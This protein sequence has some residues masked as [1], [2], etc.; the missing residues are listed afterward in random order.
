MARTGI[1]T[2]DFFPFIGG[3]GRLTYTMYCGLKRKNILFFSPAAN[4]L[5]GHVRID[6]WA[7]RFFQQVGVTIWLHFNVHRI[8]ADYDLGKLNVHSGAGGVLLFRRV[9][10]PVVVT[11][12]HTYWQHYRYIKSQFWKRIFYPFERLTYKRADL[13]VADCEDTKRVLVDRYD[14]PERKITII[15]IAVNT[16]DFFATKQ[17]KEPGTILYIGRID[18]RKGV[19]FLIRSMPLVVQQVLDARLLIGGSGKDLDKMK[20]LVSR[21]DLERNVTF[22][23]FVPDDQLNALYNQAQCVVV[24]SVFEGFGITVIEA[25]AAG[26]R[27]VGTDVDGIR[28]T[29]KSGD[30]GTLVPYGDCRA[31]ADAIVAELKDPRESE[32]LRPEYHLDQFR[33]RY[34][35]VLE[36]TTIL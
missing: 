7:V 5:P 14:V 30:Y 6:Y 20:S 28:S 29:M 8:I 34:L 26:T 24:P 36:E 33:R 1:I 9:G 32:K 18:K 19:D 35:E 3:I 31:M 23:G 27:V 17:P 13:I 22:L 4:S 25:V 15:P 10:V 11:C 2:Y 12:H 16:D 21:L